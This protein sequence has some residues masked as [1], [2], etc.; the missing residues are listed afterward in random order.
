M[1]KL[2]EAS[3]ADRPASAGERARART[4]IEGGT[5]MP[6][7][8]ITRTLEGDVLPHLDAAYNLA[9]WLTR[10]AQDAEDVVQEACLRARRCFAG[11]RGGNGRTWL[12]TIV[13]GTCYSWL[14]QNRPLKTAMASEENNWEAQNS[15]LN[16]EASPFRDANRQQFTQALEGLPIQFRE[17]L[18]LREMEDLS[19][20]QIADVTD[21]PLATVML[22][23]SGARERLRQSLA[24][25]AN[26][27]LR[28]EQRVIEQLQS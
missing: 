7:Q 23:I 28:Q 24:V 4:L 5:Y 2:A 25:V 10:N 3:K 20:K 17:L 15:S 19:Y 18:V 8:N 1:T 13:R 12:L 16:P 11:F 14:K 27:T 22:N 21:L 6:K 26:S 9:R